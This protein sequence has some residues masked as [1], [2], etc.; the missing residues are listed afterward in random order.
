MQ[1]N[2]LLSSIFPGTSAN[3]THKGNLTLVHAMAALQVS[4]GN[5]D[6]YLPLIKI[7]D[8]GPDG[9][10]YVVN[11]ISKQMQTRVVAN[12]V[13]INEPIILISREIPPLAVSD[14]GVSQGPKLYI[15][16]SDDFGLV[17]PDYNAIGFNDLSPETSFYSAAGVPHPMAGTEPQPRVGRPPNAFILYRKH[18]H[19]K[20]KKANPGFVNNEICKS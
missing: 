3:R 18:H 20:V 5:R 6:I 10:Q 14:A 4:Q 12:I 1:N 13:D 11:E 2:Q 15:G 16:G 7:A 19:E 8:I 17:A 9:L